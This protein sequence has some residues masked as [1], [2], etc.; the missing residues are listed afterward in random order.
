MEFLLRAYVCH[1]EA[2]DSG[3]LFFAFGVLLLRAG[4]LTDL[5]L[6]VMLLLDR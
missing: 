2:S 3:A 1:E 5:R 4:R 6:D